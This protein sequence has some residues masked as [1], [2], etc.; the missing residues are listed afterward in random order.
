MMNW[1]LLVMAG[2]VAIVLAVVLGGLTIPASYSVRRQIVLQSGADQVEQQLQQVSTWPV[3]LERALNVTPEPNASPG[4]VNL[5]LLGDDT[6]VIGRLELTVH[7]LESGTRVTCVESGTIGN[8]ITRFVRRYSGG[9]AQNAEAV[10]TAL[11]E[12]LN[13]FNARPATLS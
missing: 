8:P 13:E 10:L 1:I 5:S 12:Q 9:S 4:T 2:I 11:A 3:W 6:S 7:T